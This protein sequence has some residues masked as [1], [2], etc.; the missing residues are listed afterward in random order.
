MDG[1]GINVLNNA[2]LAANERLVVATM[3][4]YHALGG[5]FQTLLKYSVKFSFAHIFVHELNELNECDEFFFCS[6]I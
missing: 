1:E 5:S 6:Q 3:L 4:L 2:V